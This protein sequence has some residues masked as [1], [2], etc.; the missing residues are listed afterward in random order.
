MES[1]WVLQHA[2][3]EALG[4]I[5][6]ALEAHG[7]APHYVPTHLGQPVPREMGGKVGLVV[8]G[9]PMGVYEEEACPFLR[10]ERR[11]IGMALAEGV[12]ILGVCLGSQLLAA[13]LGAEV[14]KG[15]KKE[16]G[17][18][19]VTLTPAAAT[20]TLFTGVTPEFW[21]FHWHG[22]VFSLPAGADALAFS[23]QT[24]CQA[25]RCGENAYGILF[26]LEVTAAQII[27]MVSTFAHELAEAG[28]EPDEVTGGVPR[29]LPALGRVADAVF[30]RWAA[31]IARR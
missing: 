7:I 25:F 31:L 9:G 12:P 20:D 11:L 28:I 4:T 1:V 22:D 10:D 5:E 23:T 17:W 15:E 16:L 13:T 26:H 3:V 8:M 24:A 27:A 14:K 2:P 30:G 19:K 29:Y 6:D 21:P 18:H